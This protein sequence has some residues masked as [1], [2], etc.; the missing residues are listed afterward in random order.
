[1]FC[2]EYCL[3]WDANRL[4]SGETSSRKLADLRRHFSGCEVI[5]GSISIALSD[6]GDIFEE[7]DFDFLCHLKEITGLLRLINVTTTN[8]TLP[9]LVLIRGRQLTGG[10]N[11]LE[12]AS[13]HIDS[14]FGNLREI[15]KGHVS[16][17]DSS[18]CGYKTVNWVDILE[19][20]LLV[21]SEQNDL[22]KPNNDCKDVGEEFILLYCT[23]T[24]AHTNTHT[25]TEREIRLCVSQNEANL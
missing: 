13:S 2:V 5:D 1:M 19:D 8:L 9:N 6:P 20:G 10:G 23:H 25:Y 15:S 22:L 24:H 14:L 3:G 7:T 21:T 12:I 4:P 18:W 11:S 16:I 17:H